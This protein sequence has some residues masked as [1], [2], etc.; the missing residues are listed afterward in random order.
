MNS[1]WVHSAIYDPTPEQMAKAREDSA[2]AGMLGIPSVGSLPSTA[3]AI[4]LNPRLKVLVAQGAYD[5]LGGCSINAEHARRLES[6]Y[7]EAVQFK[8][9]DGAH[10]MYRD[11][12]ARTLSPLF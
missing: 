3:E 8:C 11:T 5:P 4:L 6:P 1:R 9:Y 2:R 7:K 10:Q 12:P